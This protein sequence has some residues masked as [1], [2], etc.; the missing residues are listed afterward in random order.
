MSPQS[1][2]L[3][4]SVTLGEASFSASGDTE[5]VLKTFADFKEWAT[6]SPSESPG[7]PKRT[8]PKFEGGNGGDPGKDEKPVLAAK[9]SLPLKPYVDRFTLKNNRMK[10]TAILAWS[11]ESG[12]KAQLTA[13]GVLDLWKKTGFRAPSNLGNLGRDLRDA[14]T[15]GWLDLH[16]TGRDQTFSINTYGEGIVQGW[17]KDKE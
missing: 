8:K 7:T 10:G 3:E 5:V 9:T 4:L 15:E 6:A 13:A 17:A 16:G 11:A 1:R 12:G 14:A 2:S